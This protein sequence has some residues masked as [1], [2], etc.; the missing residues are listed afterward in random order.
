MELKKATRKQVKLKLNISAPSGAGKTYGALLMAYGLVGDWNK[1][2]V[3]DTENRSSSLY[4]HLGPFNVVDLDAPF[5]PD[6]YIQAI[7]ICLQG[8]MECIIIDSST[9]EWSGLGGCLEMNEKLAQAKYKGNTWSAWNETTPKHDKFVQH[10]LQCNAHIITCTRSK[11][12]TVMTDDKKV[13][14]VGMKDIQRDGWEYELTV[15]LNIDRDTHMAIASKDRTELFEGK[16]PFKI[17]VETGK[18]I[19]EWCERGA[20]EEKPMPTILPDLVRG[21]EKWNTIVKGLADGIATIEKVKLKNK[22][23]PETEVLLNEDLKVYQA[24]LLKKTG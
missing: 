14:K 11:M 13:K 8:G 15:S 10:V 22:V 18:L 24:N 5:S 9:H 20:P 7:N 3:I 1:I 21:S 6:R 23:T 12:D 19:K 17:T 16:D 4:E 2:A